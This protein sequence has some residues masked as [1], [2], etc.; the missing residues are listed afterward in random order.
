LLAVSVVIAL[1]LL[2]LC[3]LIFD[4]GCRPFW[5]GAA[6]HCDI[7]VAGP[8]DC[9]FCAGGLRFAVIAAC[10]IFGALAAIVTVSRSLTT[11]FPLLLLAGVAAYLI[12]TLVAAAVLG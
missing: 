9:P 3:D 5:A 7:H 12:V 10:V 11:R 2:S 4:C 6:S 1:S 8:P